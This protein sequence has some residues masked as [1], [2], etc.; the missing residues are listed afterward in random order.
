MSV[1]IYLHVGGVGG[2]TSWA[3]FSSMKRWLSRTAFFRAWSRGSTAAPAA[4]PAAG[5]LG[6]ISACATPA[7][8]VI[9]HV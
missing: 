4:A 3:L 2:R 9:A 5:R 7:P 6:R 8:K 1:S